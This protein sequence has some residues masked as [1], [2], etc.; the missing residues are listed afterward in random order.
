MRLHRSKNY[1]KNLALIVHI[2]G[3][4]RGVTAR[5]TELD[6]RLTESSLPAR[7]PHERVALLVPTW[8][9]ETWMLHLA[10][11]AQPPEDAKLKR[12]PDPQY[13]QAM[14]TLEED[15][16]AAIR[17]AVAAWPSTAVES[18]ADGN[19]ELGRVRPD[20]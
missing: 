13:R 4:D 7:A 11:I 8:C 6:S 20:G 15:G 17:A 18:L 2:D 10:G 3:D 19:I 14:R 16:T 1:Q 9:I 5:K 12:D